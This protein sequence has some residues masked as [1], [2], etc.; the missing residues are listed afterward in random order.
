MIYAAITG[1]ACYLVLAIL[2]A[3]HSM[4]G[5]MGLILAFAAYLTLWPWLEARWQ[6]KSKT[7]KKEG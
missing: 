7:T 6:R 3:W 4:F 2:S 1:A 5:Y